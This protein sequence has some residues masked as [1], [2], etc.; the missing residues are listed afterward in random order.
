MTLT[1][2]VIPLKKQARRKRWLGGCAVVLV[3]SLVLV[4]FGLWLGRRMWQ[5]EPVYWADNRAFVMRNDTEAL[6]QMADNAFNRILG[7]LSLSSGYL[8]GGTETW[9]PTREDA[10]GVRTIRLGFDE[11]N[12]WL[13]E[14]LDDWLANQGRR[15]PAG[16]SDPMLTSDGGGLVA[17]FRYQADGIDQVFSVGM[18][19]TFLED[20]QARLSIDHVRGGRLPLPTGQVLRRLPGQGAGES[21]AVAVLLGQQAFDPVLPIDGARRARIIGMEVDEEGVAL[22][23]QAERVVDR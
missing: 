17:A 9:R 7:E 19:L 12:A 1:P 11:A 23:V 3:L 21:Q 22:V 2:T 13:T 8:A 6:T 20:G 15:L 4:L 16:L 18:S 14:R 5:S 10:L